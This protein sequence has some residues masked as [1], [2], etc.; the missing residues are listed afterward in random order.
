ML[1]IASWID[2]ALTGR[3]V[4]WLPSARLQCWMLL[5]VYTWV[6]FIFQLILNILHVIFIGILNI[7]ISVS[8]W[9]FQSTKD[10]DEACCML[11]NKWLS[12]WMRYIIC[13]L[14]NERMNKKIRTRQFLILQNIMELN[15]NIFYN[16]GIVENLKYI[17]N[18]NNNTD[19]IIMHRIHFLKLINVK[20]K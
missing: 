20:N 10:C 14:N 15:C 3:Y 9:G 8:Y 7:F 6:F 17:F 1:Y 2:C 19:T 11:P 18:S 4:T 16:L 12:I 13:Y 5:T